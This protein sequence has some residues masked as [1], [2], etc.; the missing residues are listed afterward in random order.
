MFQVITAQS[1]TTMAAVNHVKNSAMEADT[2]S[3]HGRSSTS[4]KGRGYFLRI[5]FLAL[6][7]AC[8]INID[9]IFAKQSGLS[10]YGN[11]KIPLYGRIFTITWDNQWNRTFTGIPGIKE[12]YYQSL[13]TES[14]YRLISYIDENENYVLIFAETISNEVDERNNTAKLSVRILDVFN[15]GKLKDNEDLFMT[16][17]ES[18]DDD[19]VEREDLNRVMGINL[20]DDEY[21]QRRAWLI[22]LKTGKFEPFKNFKKLN[23]WG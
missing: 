21:K 22:N 11:K 18:D 5:V 12:L 10:D 2:I 16:C 1:A 3:K 17:E 14:G 23:C 8:V 13:I 20:W 9:N 7:V 6:M 4:Q 19:S 15:I